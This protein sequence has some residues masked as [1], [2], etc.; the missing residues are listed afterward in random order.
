MAE[1]AGKWWWGLRSVWM[2]LLNFLLAFVLVSAERDLRIGPSTF[3]GTESS[4]FLRAVNFLWQ[5]LES[6]Y[7]HVWP[8]M[9]QFSL[10]PLPSTMPF[11]INNLL[12]YS[13]KMFKKY[14][15]IL[16]YY[17]YF[18]LKKIFYFHSSKKY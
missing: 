17:C 3:N 9:F 5:P 4:Y 1:F 6:S 2:V 10:F 7:Q 11:S 14:I 15:F 16:N 12:F 8:V 13:Q 18:F